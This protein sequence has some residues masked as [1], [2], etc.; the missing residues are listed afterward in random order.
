MAEKLLSKSEF[1]KLQGV[2]PVTV[3]RWL[4]RGKLTTD[5]IGP[6]GKIR[7]TKAV[8]MLSENL[9]SQHVAAAAASRAKPV[10]SKALKRKAARACVNPEI[11]LAEAQRLLAVSKAETAKLRYEHESGKLIDA[12]TTG[13]QL[14]LIARHIRDSMLGITDR[15]SAIL[16]AEPD[17]QTIRDILN[18]EIEQALEGLQNMGEVVGIGKY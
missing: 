6:G 9:S 1:A 15:M 17:E 8:R 4:S 13:N 7:V 18:A 10:T 16:A 12:K 2:S 5:C 11:S 3:S 14:F